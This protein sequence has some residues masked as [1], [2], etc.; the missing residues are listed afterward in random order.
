M[1][2]VIVEPVDWG[3]TVDVEQAG[4]WWRRIELELQLRGGNV[5]LV[6]RLDA[7]GA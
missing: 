3:W 6:H 1:Q 4:G 5:R 2:K 7:G